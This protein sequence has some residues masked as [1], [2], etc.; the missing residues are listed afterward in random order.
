M[1]DLVGL[2]R[3]AAQRHPHE[4]S[5][6]QRQRIGIA[7]ALALK[8]GFVVCDEAGIGARR[9]SAGAES[10]NLMQDCFS[11]T[12]GLTYLFIS[13]HLAVVRHISTRMR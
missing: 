4:F 12:S 7:R 10:I 3:S 9:F 2:P 8:P 5:G 1:L 11:A 13:A 6:G